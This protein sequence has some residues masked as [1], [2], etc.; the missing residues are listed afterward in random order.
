MPGRG[1]DERT[2]IVERVLAG[3]R[4]ELV[5][6]NGQHAVTEFEPAQPSGPA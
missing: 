1:W 2:F 4:V 3:G 5:G 6:L